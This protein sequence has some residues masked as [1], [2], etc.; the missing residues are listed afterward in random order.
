MNGHLR[1]LSG[2][3]KAA[4]ALG[5]KDLLR[6]PWKILLLQSLCQVAIIPSSGKEMSL[7][8]CYQ[9]SVPPGLVSDSP[10]IPWKYQEEG[11][12]KGKACSAKCFYLVLCHDKLCV[13]VS[14]NTSV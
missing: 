11:S 5:F 4:Q 13:L 14:L 7:I 2:L 6:N 8:N 10:G 12:D 9:D 3:S 1:M